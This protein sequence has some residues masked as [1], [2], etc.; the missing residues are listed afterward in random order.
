MKRSRTNEILALSQLRVIFVQ[1]SSYLCP[2]FEWSLVW[3]KRARAARAR[4]LLFIVI[5]I[6]G[7]NCVSGLGLGCNF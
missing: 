2:S 5:I 3:G 7:V 4:R 6:L 1:A